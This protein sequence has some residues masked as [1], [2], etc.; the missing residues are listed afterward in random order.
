M[1]Q[2]H[3]TAVV[4]APLRAFQRWLVGQIMEIAFFTVFWPAGTNSTLF[5][6]PA[7]LWVAERV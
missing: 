2:L 3:K 4:Q 1:S 5:S 6:W 7:S